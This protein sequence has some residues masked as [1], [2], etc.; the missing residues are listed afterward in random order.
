M[1]DEVVTTALLSELGYLIVC[2][3]K[4]SRVVKT[5]GD[6]TKYFLQKNFNDNLAKLLPKPLDIAFN[7]LRTTVLQTQK[8]AASN[9]I[10]IKQGEGVL[11]INLSVSPLSINNQEQQLLMV[12]FAED[13]AAAPQGQE[14]FVFDEKIYRDQHTLHLEAELKE[15]KHK[16]HLAAEKTAASHENLQFSNEEM[17]AVNDKLHTIN[18][19]YQ[20]KNKELLELNDDLNNYF[21]S[22]I[23]GQL[24]INKDM[25][26][27]KFSP[28]AVKLINLIESDIGSPIGNITTNIKFETLTEDIKKVLQEDC[29]VTKEIEAIDGKWYQVITMP[30]LQQPDNAIKGAI[31]TF[32]DITELKRTQV[33]LDKKNKGLQRVNADLNNFVH[34]VSHDLLGPLSNIEGCVAVI[35]K[36]EVQ[37][38]QLNKFLA[39]INSS[40][41]KF[42]LLIKDIATIAKIESEMLAMEMVDLEE[43]MGTIEW[44]LD[45]KIKSSGAVIHKNFEVKQILFSKKNLRSIVYN[46]VSNAIKFKSEGPPVIYIRTATISGEIVLTVQDNGIGIPSDGIDRIFDMYGRLHR[47]VEGYGIGLYLAKKI[48]HAASGNI[49]VESEPGKGSMFS[50]YFK[51]GPKQG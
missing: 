13:K 9:G 10:K 24:F 34:T 33:E 14:D 32:N 43:M 48:I 30:Y 11:M 26:L 25:L 39:I 46:L 28:S 7:T 23:N 40:V 22:N 27:M 44:S 17:Q 5:Y 15:L 6:T 16:L 18:L 3:D 2:I 31:L 38:E 49:T 36:M 35:H 4:N 8:R 29:T 1:L 41:K 47:D 20:L 19:D 45:N 12:T 21:R 37:D 50:I 51:A 42:R